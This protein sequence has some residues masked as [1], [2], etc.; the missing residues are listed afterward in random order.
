[1]T[2][3]EVL[4][5]PRAD[6]VKK[7]AA[8]ATR[9]GRR[10]QRLF[11]AEGPQPVREAL[12]LW[13]RHWEQGA[14]PE[15]TAAGLPTLDALYFDA[16]ALAS[17]PDVQALLDQARGELY[18]PQSTLPREARFFLR[19]ATAEVLAAMGDT[20]TSQGVLAVC[21]IPET[22]GGEGAGDPVDVLLGAADAAGTGPQPAGLVA[23]LLSLQDPGNVGT[24]IRTAD[25]AGAAAVVLIPG[26]ADPWAPKVVRSA[27]GSHFHLP[28]VAGVDPQRLVDAARAAGLQVLAADAGGEASLPDLEHPAAPTLWLLG[29]EA[30]GL[31]AEHQALADVRVSIP[32]YGQAE[33]L[34]VATAATV[35]LYASAMARHDR[36][37]GSIPGS[38]PTGR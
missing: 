24:I 3:P 19:E 34:N 12:A 25:A 7:V 35:C 26:S 38:V 27:A 15:S 6:R 36:A 37:S 2:D 5:N 31:S 1:M 29:N 4:S 9:A 23:G 22:R 11:L 21:R 18:D 30:H 16:E 28:L 33:S 14:G 13:L 20:E 8:L 32:L 17:H 10:R